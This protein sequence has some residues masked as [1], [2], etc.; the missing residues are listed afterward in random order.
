MARLHGALGWQHAFGDTV[1]SS[2]ARFGTGD[3]FTI[4]SKPLDRDALVLET[5]LDLSLSSSATLGVGY[6][7]RIGANAREHGANARL[8]LTF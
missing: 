7:G 6:S 3:S 8:R 5:G 2:T 4:F 1:A